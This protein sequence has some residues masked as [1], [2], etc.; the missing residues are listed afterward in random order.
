MLELFYS[1]GMRL[2]EL[3]GLD[4]RALDLIADQVRVMG[5]GR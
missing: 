3:A 5:K 1:T 2:S 4:L